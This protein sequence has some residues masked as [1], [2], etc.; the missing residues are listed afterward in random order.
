ML[1][2]TMSVRGAQW[3][4]FTHLSGRVFSSKKS[5]FRGR[6][7]GLVPDRGYDGNLRTWQGLPIMYKSPRC[8]FP[9]MA[10][11]LL[12]SSSKSTKF[13]VRSSLLRNSQDSRPC[14]CTVMEGKEKTNLNFTRSC[15]AHIRFHTTNS[16]LTRDR[17]SYAASINRWNLGAISFILPSAAKPLCW[18]TRVGTHHHHHASAAPTQGLGCSILPRPREEGCARSADKRRREGAREG[19]SNFGASFLSPQ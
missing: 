6:R 19:T 8:L 5:S 2:E 12:S 3:A 13:T 1:E 17:D 15:P 16:W 11:M 10:V 9:S 7:V 14:T 4:N 18:S